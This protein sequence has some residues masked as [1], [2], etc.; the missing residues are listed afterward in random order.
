MRR[1]DNLTAFVGVRKLFL[2]VSPE[3]VD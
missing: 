1:I 3:D 2:Y